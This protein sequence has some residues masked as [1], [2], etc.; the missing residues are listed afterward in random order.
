M[1]SNSVVPCLKT[2]TRSWFLDSL[3]YNYY[4]LYLD[5]FRPR[6]ILLSWLSYTAL[7]LTAIY[8]IFCMLTVCALWIIVIKW[9][10][11]ADPAQKQKKGICTLM[12]NTT[13]LLNIALLLTTP[14]KSISS[15]WFLLLFLLPWQICNSLYRDHASVRNISLCTLT[16]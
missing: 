10:Q 4:F 14:V 1:T 8:F 16:C 9:F 2:P 6:P 12:T 7:L 15:S 3:A 5:S 11:K 13:W